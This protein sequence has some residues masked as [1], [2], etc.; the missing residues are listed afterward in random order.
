MN[1]C[2]ALAALAVLVEGRLLDSPR[3]RDTPELVLRST[4]MP[5]VWH[6]PETRE[7]RLF[8]Y[9]MGGNEPDYRVYQDERGDWTVH[10]H[11]GGCADYQ[12]N[13]LTDALDAIR[14]DCESDSPPE[15]EGDVY[16]ATVEILRYA[17]SAQRV[18]VAAG[19]ELPDHPWRTTPDTR[20]SEDADQATKPCRNL[21][22][23]FMRLYDWVSSTP[24]SRR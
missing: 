7:G 1:S 13:T 17:P 19:C 3:T 4:F 14:V 11:D 12:C 22:S 20:P 18:T 10:H 23:P 5:S 24:P 9:E 16:S 8:E 15:G 21:R 6:I 2:T